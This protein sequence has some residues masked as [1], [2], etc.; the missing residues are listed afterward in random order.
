M[1]LVGWLVNPLEDCTLTLKS[2]AQMLAYQQCEVKIF[3]HWLA[4]GRHSF[5]N[6]SGMKNNGMCLDNELFCVFRSRNK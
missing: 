6:T 1:C 3:F 4:E 2:D 5:I